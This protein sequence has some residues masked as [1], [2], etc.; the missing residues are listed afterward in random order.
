MKDRHRTVANARTLLELLGRRNRVARSSHTGILTGWTPGIQIIDNISYGAVAQH[1]IYISNSRVSPDDVVVRGNECYGNGQNG[2][3]LNGDC[4]EG[5]DGIISNA[6][7]EDNFVHDN[8][9]KGFSLISVQG[10]LIRNN[11]IWNNGILAGA[12]G[13]HLVDQ[14]DCSKPSNANVVVNNTIIEPRIAGI[15]INL[16]SVANVIFN[17][18]VV[19]GSSDYTIVDEVTGNW[20]DTSSNILRTSSTGLF[21]NEANHDYHLADGSAAGS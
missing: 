9:W 14:P 7:I 16:G 2:V 8:N 15:R 5:G 20:I 3:Q 17:N 11:V 19:A 1:G 6:I 13:I 18:L 21:V 4:W 10:S 12:G